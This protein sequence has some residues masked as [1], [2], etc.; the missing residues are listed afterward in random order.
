MPVDTGLAVGTETEM[1]PW[2]TPPWR[3]GNDV[4]F[5]VG[6]GFFLFSIHHP[7]ADGKGDGTIFSFLL[8]APLPLEYF[9]FSKKI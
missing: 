9:L 6:I 1:W 4:G 2:G 5:A 7:Y 8:N 3:R